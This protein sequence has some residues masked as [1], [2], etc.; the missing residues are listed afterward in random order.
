MF[1]NIFLSIVP[2]DL[3]LYPA[4]PVLPDGALSSH[5]VAPRFCE[6]SL[7]IL[8]VPAGTQGARLRKAARL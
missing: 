1:L 4:P 2:F 5:A 6:F 7:G 3:G 8:W